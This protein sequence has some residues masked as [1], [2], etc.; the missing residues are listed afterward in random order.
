MSVETG[1][2]RVGTRALGFA[3][4]LGQAG[5]L[6]ARTFRAAAAG[7]VEWKMLVAQMIEMGNRSLPIV[8]LVAFFT[9]MV[10]ALQAG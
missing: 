7:P 9:C 1:L 5:T 3:T 4:G 6:L 2:A 10:L 8:M